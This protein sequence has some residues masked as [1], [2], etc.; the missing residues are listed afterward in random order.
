META[1]PGLFIK[2]H[3]NSPH[4]WADNTLAKEADGNKKV[5]VFRKADFEAGP[6]CIKVADR[7]RVVHFEYNKEGTEVWT[8]V[9]HRQ[10]EI[11]IFDDKTLEVKKR[12]KGDWLVTP[13]GK[14][15]V[16]NTVNDIY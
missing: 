13:T 9:W 2:T 3:P 16:Y 5:C 7:G 4:V 1:G 10:G 11:V 15:N 6:K 14:W 12:I 8:S